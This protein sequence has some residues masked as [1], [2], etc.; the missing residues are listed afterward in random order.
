MN[1]MDA[2]LD[3]YS[4][5]IRDLAT[6]NKLPLCDLRSLFKAYGEKNNPSDLAKGILTTDGVHLNDRGNQALAEALLPLVR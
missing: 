2:D 5:A 1:E 6:K 3:K 4:G